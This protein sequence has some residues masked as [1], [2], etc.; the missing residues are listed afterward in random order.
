RAALAKASNGAA[1]VSERQPR[2]RSSDAKYEA[3]PTVTSM[4]QQLRQSDEEKHR[5]LTE[6][7]GCLK[8]RSVLPDSQDIRH[9]AQL[10]GL[11]EISG[12][13]RKEMLP[14]LMRFLLGEPTE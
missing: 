4:L 3:N 13:S 2:R 11:K 12:R 1:E 7:Y 14:T 8:D 9:F 6:F 5:V 10:I